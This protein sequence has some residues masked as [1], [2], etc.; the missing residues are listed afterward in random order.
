MTTLVKKR[1]PL[2]APIGP[3]GQPILPKKTTTQPIDYISINKVAAQPPDI[4]Q[5]TPDTPPDMPQVDSV[6][7]PIRQPTAPRPAGDQLN[8]LISQG[9]PQEHGLNKFLDTVGGATKIGSA[10]E[11]ASGLGT[12][13]YDAK[14]ERAKTGA[15][16]EESQIEAGQKEQKS[17]ADVA[18]TRAGSELVDPTAPNAKILRKNAAGPSTAIINSGSREAVAGINQAGAT[19]REGMR[20]TAAQSLQSNKPVTMDEL[21][22]QATQEGDNATL[23]KI[24]QYKETIARS[25]QQEPGSFIPVNDAAGNIT[26]WY[27]PKSNHWVPAAGAAGGAVDQSAGGMGA[28]PR[29]PSALETRTAK[30]AEYT[31]ALIDDG[32]TM[33]NEAQAELGPTGGRWN[34]FATGRV[35]LPSV[36]WT[37]VEAQMDLIASAARLAHSQGRISPTTLQDVQNLLNA[38]KQD[39]Q[40]IIAALGTLKKA[41]GL[42]QSTFA[43]AVKPATAAGGGAGA[44]AT[45][46]ASPTTGLK[47]TRD[48]NGRIIGVE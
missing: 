26:G 27:N 39:P 18:E 8:Q 35:G 25:G 2:Q 32:I 4:Q 34:D 5:Q 11:R 13:G 33:V 30:N 40:N 6:G 1:D 28:V 21:A 15:E 41:M 42:A 16:A 10:I 31:S 3:I 20:E 24:Q 17:A 37:E 9:P 48:A 44:G 19:Q 36:Q 38:G 12:Q 29:K 23:A 14:V 45:T 22:A 7:T 47:V 43:G 46:P